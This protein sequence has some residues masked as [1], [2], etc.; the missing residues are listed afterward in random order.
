MKFG[1]LLFGFSIIFAIYGTALFVLNLLKPS[2]LG[3]F[4]WIGSLILS[5]FLAKLA[6]KTIRRKQNER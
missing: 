1:I 6:N 2:L 3:T 5:Y 4:L